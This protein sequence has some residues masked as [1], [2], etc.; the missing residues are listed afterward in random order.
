MTQST[1]GSFWGRVTEKTEYF[2]NTNLYFALMLAV[3]AVSMLTQ[4]VVPSTVALAVLCAWMLVFC[5]DI[6]AAALPFLLIFLLST[7][8]Y[9]NL[10][11]FLPCAPRAALV[12]GGFVVVGLLSGDGDKSADACSGATWESIGLDR[13]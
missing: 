11:V 12:I 7:L 10:S 1:S 3:T 8:Q 2:W 5:R 13:K 6:L 4:N 9:E